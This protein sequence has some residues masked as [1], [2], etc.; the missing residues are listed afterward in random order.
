MKDREESDEFISRVGEKLFLHIAKNYWQYAASLIGTLLVAAGSA[1][2]WAS[3]MQ[4][5]LEDVTRKVNAIY[6]QMIPKHSYSEEPQRSDGK[7]PQD[8]GIPRVDMPR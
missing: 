6:D 5:K 2:W 1:I 7:R 8:A 3:S 4:Q